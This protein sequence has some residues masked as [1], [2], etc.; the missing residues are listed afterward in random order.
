MCSSAYAAPP[1]AGHWNII[2]PSQPDYFG[3]VLI[4]HQ[5]RVTLDAP[6]DF[7]RPA[8]YRGYTAEANAATVKFMMTDGN[9]V[10]RIVCAVQSS[11]LLTCR[12]FYSDGTKSADYT[13]TRIG[14]GPASLLR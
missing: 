13:L 9:N 14:P 2:V 12:T 3:T 4:D 5:G 7:G 11:E 6:K 10:V 8:R 1:L